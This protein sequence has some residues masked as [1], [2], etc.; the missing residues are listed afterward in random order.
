MEFCFNPSCPR[1]ISYKLKL[2]SDQI[3]SC[4]NP[5]EL[6][7]KNIIPILKNSEGTIFMTG[8]G[9]SSHITKKCVSTWQSLGINT[10]NLLIQD[11]FHGDIGILTNRDIIIYITNSGN[12]KE[13]LDASEYIQKNFTLKQICISSNPSA[14]LNKIV[15]HSYTICNFKIKEADILDII[16][17]VSTTMFMMLL[18]NIGIHLA[19]IRGFNKSKFKINHPSGDI[20]KKL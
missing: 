19:E 3:S 8:I 17:S 13:L 6:I 11:L 10:H 18:D 5:F 14:Q 1:N 2:Y 12:T 9:K 16:P 4:N 20:G 15:D 7:I